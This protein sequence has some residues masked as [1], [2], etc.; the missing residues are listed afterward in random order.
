[1]RNGT[2]LL[3]RQIYGY[4]VFLYVSLHVISAHLDPRVPGAG[5]DLR[6]RLL[7]WNFW[8]RSEPLL[9]P[10]LFN[11]EGLI[12]TSS[13]VWDFM[14]E[15]EVEVYETRKKKEAKLYGRSFLPNKLV[16]LCIFRLFG[17]KTY[18]K[19]AHCSGSTFPAV[20]KCWLHKMYWSR[21]LSLSFE[22]TSILSYS[23]FRSNARQ[24]E[25]VMFLLTS[26]TMEKLRIFFVLFYILFRR[27]KTGFAWTNIV[28]LLKL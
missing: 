3:L 28:L 15:N 16:Q 20:F 1:M 26:L 25:D 19:M 12:V 27:K 23:R 7:Y 21:K 2:P 4:A 10:S 24:D 9:R 13:F 11:L 17:S 8:I 14:D 18:Q 22:R 6:T 5:R